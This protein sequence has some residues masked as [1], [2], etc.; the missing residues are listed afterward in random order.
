M[1]FLI[2]IRKIWFD[3]QSQFSLS[4]FSRNMNWFINKFQRIPVSETDQDRSQKN[5]YGVGGFPKILRN[6][7]SGSWQILTSNYKVGGWG[8]KRPKTCLRNTW[9][10]P[11][12]W[13]PAKNNPPQIFCGECSKL[14]F[15]SFAFSSLRNKILWP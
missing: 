7:Q 11:K 13:C 2:S 8:E 14:F 10:V 9:M 6:L 4:K 1:T 12:L 15:Q 5:I 3:L